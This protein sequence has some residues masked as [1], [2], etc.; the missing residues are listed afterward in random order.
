MVP[1]NLIT[2]ATNMQSQRS[3]PQTFSCEFFP[4]N[5]LQAR[6]RLQATRE[7]LGEIQP[8][9]FSVTYGAG[10]SSRDRTR[11][12]VLEIQQQSHFEAAPHLTCVAATREETL[13][14]LQ[15]Y[16][17]QGIRRIVALRGDMPSGE[18]TVGDFRYA[19]DLVAFIRAE[20][21]DHF[22]IEVAA[23]P[24]FHPQCTSTQQDLL[25]YRAKVDAGANGAI[26]QY[27]FNPD[28]YFRFID[29]CERL[30]MDIPVVPGIMPITNTRQ[31]C[32]FSDMCGAEIPRWIRQ[33]LEDF[34]DDRDGL[35]SFG[36]EVVSALC[37]RLLEQGCPGLHF[38][39]MNQA[40]PVLAICRNLGISNR[41]LPSP[42]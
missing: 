31:L 9:F 21:G 22:Y 10:G 28:A 19:R 35:L 33:R 20:T 24:E 7:A 12:A 6:Q 42:T 29:S 38:Y 40:G 11:E 18:N 27:F 1:T 15:D 34:G 26:T 14:I 17:Q 39:T 41:T 8:A 4:P 5:N 32:R 36:V 13:E 16:Q 30:G 3:Y 37:Q 23:Y 25:H 2:T